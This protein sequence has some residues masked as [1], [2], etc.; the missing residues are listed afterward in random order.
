MIGY[1]D[2]RELSIAILSRQAPHYQVTVKEPLKGALHDGGYTGLCEL[3]YITTNGFHDH[4]E[5]NVTVYCHAWPHIV[6]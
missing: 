4:R 5:L 3:N 2:H 6:R 1:P